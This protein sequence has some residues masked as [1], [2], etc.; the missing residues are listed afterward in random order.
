MFCK[1]PCFSDDYLPTFNRPNVTLVDTNGRGVDRFTERGV[2]VGDT[3]YELDCVVF[4][5][6]FDFGTA[7]TK[8]AGFDVVGRD[9]VRLSHKWAKRLSTFHG[10]HSHGFPNMFHLGITET[11]YTPNY[12]HML[13]E[14]TSH[15]AHIVAHCRKEGATYLEADPDAEA[16][17]V[18]TINRLRSST[19]GFTPSAPL[20][21]TTRKEC[22]TATA[23]WRA[24][25]ARAPSPSSRCY[26]NG[27]KTVDSQG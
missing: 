11:G 4:A 26:T 13:D 22:L 20:A 21:T 1:R 27:A 7:R 9:G 8:R 19:N 6:G 16:E 18:A 23:C 3:E 25:T 12:P 17:W 5:T 14:Q 15:I 2:V 10:L 24:S